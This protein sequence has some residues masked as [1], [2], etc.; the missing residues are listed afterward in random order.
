MPLVEPQS[1]EEEYGEEEAVNVRTQL[2][3]FQQCDIYRDLLKS[4]QVVVPV[5]PADGMN[6]QLTRMLSVWYGEG[7][8]WSNI[9]DHMGGFIEMTR[10][11]IAHHFIHNDQ[12][13]RFLLMIDN[14][15]E[16]PLNLPYLL[17]RHNQPVVGAPAATI[18]QKYGLQ[19]C[20]TVKDTEGEYRF[21]CMKSG[22]KIPG[23]GLV[24]AGHSG[25]GAILIRRDV[26]ESF[27]FKD[28]DIP[29]YVPED[30]RTKGAET[31]HLMIGEDI[32]F[33]NAVREK[34]FKIHVDLEAHCRHRKTVPIAWP[35]YAIDREMP[36]DGFVLPKE[37]H[38][39]SGG[40]GANKS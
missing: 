32:A 25:T 2:G 10:A 24:E 13:A 4:I 7:T 6:C 38:K 35:E 1:L 11:N 12:H 31:G 33:C 23:S 5:R 22:A 37:G 17:A 39:I 9:N 8:P 21:P 3:Y 34:G 36:L 16:P 20:F 15:M 27:T 40:N 26:L 28:G 30:V 18:T 29:F 14:D 19:L